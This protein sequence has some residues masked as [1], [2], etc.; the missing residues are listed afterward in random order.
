MTE[1]TDNETDVAKL[2]LADLD[3]DSRTASIGW[4]AAPTWRWLDAI[5]WVARRDPELMAFV[6]GYRFYIRR[7]MPRNDSER[8]CRNTLLAHGPEDEWRR[9]ERLLITAVED[10]RIEARHG[11]TGELAVLGYLHGGKSVLEPV[12]AADADLTS[13]EVSAASV[14]AYAERLTSGDRQELRPSDRT[15]APG[16]PT[17]MHLIEQM[18]RERFEQKE[19][20]PTI[21]EEASELVRLYDEREEYKGLARITPKTVKNKLASLF[22][23]LNQAR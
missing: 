4:Q 8:C 1:T 5:V 13:L 18:M 19:T 21:T 23:Q 17:P 2:T 14:R 12:G 20:R 16:R 15:G 9:A 10:G 22:R 11:D 7:E 3:D 6:R